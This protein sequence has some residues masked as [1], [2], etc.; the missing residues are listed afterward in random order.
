[1]QPR[2]EGQ[3]R[4]IPGY[5]KYEIDQFGN[6]RKLFKSRASLP[7]TVRIKND[8]CIVRLTGPDGRR[9]EERVHKLMQRTFMR[10]PYPN[11]V[12]YHKNQNRQDNC[13]ANLTYIDRQM[14]GRITGAKSRRRPVA[15][16]NCHGETVEV[17]SSAREAARRNHMSY[18]TVMDRCNGRVKNTFALDGYRYAWDDIDIEELSHMVRV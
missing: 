5:P 12:L 7:I 3:C 18:Q 8:I 10:R 9:K 13:L 2:E 11:E 1:M 14:L 17:Y 15:K 16:I 6:I 4:R